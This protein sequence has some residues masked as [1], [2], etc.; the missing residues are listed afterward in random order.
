MASTVSLVTL[1]LFA[2][3][4]ISQVALPARC[5]VLDISVPGSTGADRQKPWSLTH[6]DEDETARRKRDTNR[7]SNLFGIL[8]MI[9]DKKNSSEPND[10]N[11]EGGQKHNNGGKQNG[12]KNRDKSG[13]KNR[14]KN[15]RK[16]RDK[17]G[18]K[19]RDQNGPKPRN[20]NSGKQDDQNSRK[21]RDQNGRKHGDQ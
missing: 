2:L 13:S 17:N 21:H 14:D 5:E 11:R 16:N 3:V 9:R 10:G 8:Q 1:P 4:F 12:R 15:G 7:E 6:T 19:Y 20:K 18:R